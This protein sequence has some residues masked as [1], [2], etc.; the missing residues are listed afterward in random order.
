[1]PRIP[2]QKEGGWEGG[3]RAQRK[4]SV[5]AVPSTDLEGTMLSEI[6]QSHLIP[7]PEDLKKVG[8]VE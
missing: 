2:W 6:D 4:R 1:M 7:L 8:P 3:E 5:N